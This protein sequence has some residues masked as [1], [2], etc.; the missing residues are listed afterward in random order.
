MNLFFD[1]LF[2]KKTPKQEQPAKPRKLYHRPTRRDIVALVS[3]EYGCST[4]EAEDWLR[5]EFYFF[6][7]N[8]LRMIDGHIAHPFVRSE[9]SEKV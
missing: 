5:D 7:Q 9:T 8:Y 2:G 1:A 4:R 3:H 6:D